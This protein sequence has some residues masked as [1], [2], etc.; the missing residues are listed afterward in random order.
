MPVDPKFCNPELQAQEFRDAVAALGVGAELTSKDI[1]SIGIEGA[2]AH[3]LR[4]ATKE[5]FNFDTPRLTLEQL[6]VVDPK[7]RFASELAFERNLSFGEGTIAEAIGANPKF[8]E[9]VFNI[10]TMASLAGISPVMAARGYTVSGVAINTHTKGKNVR[11]EVSVTLTKGDKDIQVRRDISSSRKAE[12]SILLIDDKRMGLGTASLRATFSEYKRLGVKH[13]DVSTQRDGNKVWALAGYQP[14]D[15][16]GFKRGIKKGNRWLTPEDRKFLSKASL[17]DI[18]KHTFSDGTKFTDRKFA[19]GEWDGRLTLGSKDQKKLALFLGD[20]KALDTHIAA[21]ATQAQSDINTAVGG[22]EFLTNLVKVGDP[23]K[24]DPQKTV[25]TLEQ[26]TKAVFAAARKISVSSALRARLRNPSKAFVTSPTTDVDAALD[27]L[28]ALGFNRDKLKIVKKGDQQAVKVPVG[29]LRRIKREEAAL[30][31]A[32]AAAKKAAAVEKKAAAAAEKKAKADAKKAKADAKKEKAEKKKA[33]AAAKKEKAAAKKAAKA[34]KA[35][36]KKLK[37]AAKKEKA[38]KKKSDKELKA[39]VAE[40]TKKV[41]ALVAKLSAKFSKAPPVVVG[42]TAK[43]AKPTTEQ[44]TVGSVVTKFGALSDE[45]GALRIK[46]LGPSRRAAA[47]EAGVKDLDKKQALAK[48]ERDK[49]WKETYT[50]NKGPDTEKVL[51]AITLFT[52]GNVDTVKNPAMF[53]PALEER[54]L[55]NSVTSFKDPSKVFQSEGTRADYKSANKIITELSKAPLTG[56]DV[57]YRG[58]SL[59]GKLVNSFK[60]GSAFD[61][62]ISSFSK[63]ETVA[64]NFMEAAARKFE[65][66]QPVMFKVKKPVRG[67]DISKVSYYAS[68][69]EVVSSGRFK[70]VKIIQHGVPGVPSPDTHTEFVLE[71]VTK[72]AEARSK[73][74]AL[75]KAEALRK[76]EEKAAEAQAKQAARDAKKLAKKILADRKAAEKAAAKKKAPEPLIPAEVVAATRGIDRPA[77][78]RATK[79]LFEKSAAWNKASRDFGRASKRGDAGRAE[80]EALFAEGSETK[81]VADA[82]TLFTGGNYGVVIDPTLYKTTTHRIRSSTLSTQNKSGIINANFAADVSKKS[83]E[84]A[85]KILSA[86][87]S[88]PIENPPKILFRGVKLSNELAGALKKKGVEFEL[89]VSSFSGVKRVAVQFAAPDERESGR[90]P[91]IFELKKVKTGTDIS[92]ISTAPSEQEVVTTGKFKVVGSRVK[93]VNGFSVRHIQIE[94]L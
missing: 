12:N 61:L 30:K 90:E 38:L 15:L 63:D 49:Y 87:A 41:N 17:E 5:P 25:K 65:S 22:V 10:D 67:T 14:K 37:E 53:D 13:V 34:A 70:V 47:A 88:T 89:P 36:K 51:D 78:N 83:Y 28:A 74:E 55:N 84:D 29:E 4:G 18:T 50:K 77:V 64:E 86:L 39:K 91:I 80:L 81:R 60:V 92:A 56:V 68:E 58:A 75:K 8:V 79:N 59:P 52:N 72:E 6:A 3:A 26:S 32:A 82:V 7:G 71:Q 27:S 73:K 20:K 11:L 21:K 85:H 42:E 54:V 31:K 43:L 94:Q 24:F 35:L 57:I 69:A 48:K 40:S 1:K 76:K 19:V 93:K 62:P 33:A 66:T 16:S 2:A 23:R 44:K 46:V 9:K 45:M